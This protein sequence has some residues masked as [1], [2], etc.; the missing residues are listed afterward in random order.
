[1]DRTRRWIVCSTSSRKS[2]GEIRRGYRAA[3][4]SVGGFRTFLRQ[5]PGVLQIKL[6]R[7][8]VLGGCVVA[9]LIV[10][11]SGSSDPD[12]A[13][14]SVNKTNIERLANLYFTYQSLHEWH[15]PPDESQFKSFL[16]G[17]NAHKLSRIGVDPNALDQLFV[18]ERD[19]QPFKIRYGVQGSSMGSMAPVIFESVG[20]GKG[21]MVGFLNMEQR[22]VN[23]SE[24]NTLWSEKVSTTPQRGNR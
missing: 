15:G 11:C 1:M 16:H 5:V 2:R 13:I 3:D 19:G 12:S 22:E 23:E 7:W 18:S 20:N 17:Y 24:Y 9:G 8:G 21:R 4:R 6:T 14:A 10:G